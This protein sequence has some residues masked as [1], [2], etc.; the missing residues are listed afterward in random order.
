M[1]Y[2]TWTTIYEPKKKYAPNADD[3]ECTG[4]NPIL[5]QKCLISMSD[6]E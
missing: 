4:G 2:N 6:L 1:T 5:K 3:K